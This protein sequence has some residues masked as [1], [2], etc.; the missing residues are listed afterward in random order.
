MPFDGT[1]EPDRDYT[2]AHS[3]LIDSPNG[4]MNQRGAIHFFRPNSLAPLR[5]QKGRYLLYLDLS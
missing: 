5:S 2:F 4:Q 1:G 3:L